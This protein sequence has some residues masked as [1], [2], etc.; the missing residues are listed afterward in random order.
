MLQREG[1][2]GSKARGQGQTWGLKYMRNIKK[3]SVV[4]ARQEETEARLHRAL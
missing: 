1:T 3:A 2:A 4:T